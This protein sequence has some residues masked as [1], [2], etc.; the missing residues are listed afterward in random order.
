MKIALITI[1]RVNNYGAVLQAY[2]TK[3]ALS[4]YGEV[5]TIDY[6]NRHLSQHLD[7]VRF[8]PSI[9]GF[10][11]FAHDILRLRN[12][13]KMLKSFRDFITSNMNLTKPYSAQELI[14]GKASGYDLYV[15]G[16]DQIWNPIIVSPNTTIDPIFFLSFVEKN[17]NKIAYASSIGNYNFNDS[18]KIVVNDLLSSYN[19][20]STRESGGKK[21]LEE[22]IP[23]KEIY[24]VVDPTLLLSRKEWLN[25]FNLKEKE[26]KEK[27][28]LVYSV[29]RTELLKNAV[30]YYSEKL[31]LKVIVIDSML[32]PVTRIGEHI[33]DAGPKEFIELY[34]NASFVISDSFHGTCFATIFAKPF[35]SVVSKV[36]S[37]RVVSLLNLLDLNDRLIYDE[38]DFSNL[39]LDI[40]VN[41]LE[42]NLTKIRLESLQYL[43]TSIKNLN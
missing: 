40:D 30:K 29:P 9:H 3:I 42:K 26:P 43:D 33:K 25:V 2:A 41:K 8:A 1:H 38:S 7:L 11:M 15:S 19:Y 21:K 4:K 36:R 39:K 27:Y 6:N 16:S 20:I 12:R 22:I 24:H 18:E 35:A 28:I 23:K 34:S 37:S 10:K 5:S 14:D 13:T 31:N 17:V 32:I